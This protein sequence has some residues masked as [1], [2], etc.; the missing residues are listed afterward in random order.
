ME[1]DLSDY[2]TLFLGVDIA[3]IAGLY[4]VG[5]ME[6]HEAVEMAK[7]DKQDLEASLRVMQEWVRKLKLDVTCEVKGR[8]EYRVD[9][10]CEVCRIVIA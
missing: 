8:E 10:L 7:L 2:K 5:G 4:V 1:R 3:A 9:K 6:K